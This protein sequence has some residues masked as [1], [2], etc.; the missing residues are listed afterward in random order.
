MS[1]TD[2]FNEVLSVLYAEVILHPKATDG[3]KRGRTHLKGC[4][5]IMVYLL[6]L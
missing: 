1:G 5:A 6:P 2:Q 3:V 4:S